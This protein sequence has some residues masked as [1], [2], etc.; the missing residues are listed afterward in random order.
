MQSQSGPQWT[1]LAIT[2][3]II[4]LVLFLR[5][6]NMRRT[7]R[8]RLETLWIIPAIIAAVAATV[9]ATEPPHGL[10]WLY[11]GL[12]LMAGA[13]LGWQRGKLMT[14]N[15]NPQTHELNQ[16][17]SPAAIIFLVLLIVIRAGS[18]AV[19]LEMG[20]GPKAIAI[21]TDVLLVFALGLLAA[22]RIE[23][24]IRARGLL[25]QVRGLS[26]EA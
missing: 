26:Q 20:G 6:R 8:L 22:Q 3:A 15:V 16:S 7:R 17:A 14:I 24:F 25:A 13:G 2:A 19:A 10:V 9:F 21:A 1:S 18:R 12:A 23:M 5:L 4:C 11:C